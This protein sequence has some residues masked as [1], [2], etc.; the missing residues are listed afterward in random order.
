MCKLISHNMQNWHKRHDSPDLASV[1]ANKKG[2]GGLPSRALH[3][4]FSLGQTLARPTPVS[5]VCVCHG[6]RHRRRHRR[7]NRQGG[8]HVTR[9]AIEGATANSQCA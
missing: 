2:H 3:E 8:R 9:A 4:D 6:V 5:V 7:S 1:I